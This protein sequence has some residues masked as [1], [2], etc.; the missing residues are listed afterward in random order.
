MIGKERWPVLALERQGF[1]QRS[2]RLIEY[3][4]KKVVVPG[5]DG[6]LVDACDAVQRELIENVAYGGTVT[7]LLIKDDAMNVVQ[8]SVGI[9]SELCRVT[10][11]QTKEGSKGSDPDPEILV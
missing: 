9:D 11:A 6:S 2:D 1:D 3:G 8:Q 7:L 4:P 5:Q 10:L